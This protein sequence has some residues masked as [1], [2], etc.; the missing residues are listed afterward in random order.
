MSG[1][2]YSDMKHLKNFEVFNEN[3]TDIELQ[4]DDS[5]KEKIVKDGKKILTFESFTDKK[6]EL[7]NG[8]EN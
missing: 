6:V 1:L 3:L 7:I 5:M 4:E 8:K 2:I